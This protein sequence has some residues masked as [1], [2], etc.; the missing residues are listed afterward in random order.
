MRKIIVDHIE[1]LS[2]NQLPKIAKRTSRSIEEVQ[3]ALE[4]ISHL[5]PI[6]GRLFRTDP[7]PY[8]NPD[9]VLELIDGEYEIQLQ[10]DYYPKLGISEAYLKMYMDKSLDPKLRMHFRKKIESAKWLIESIEQRRSTLSRVVDVLVKHQRDFLDRGTKHLKP[11]KMQEV[12]DKLGLHVSTIS[13]TISDKYVQ[14]PRGIFSLKSFFTGATKSSDGEVESRVGVKQKVKD[15]I[16][17]EN[18]TKPLSDQEIMKILEMEGLSIARRTVTKYRKAL[19]VPS[20][21]QRRVY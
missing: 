12:A 17:N 8:V 7:I 10:N 5:D 21:R 14:A 9:V 16:D 6:P 4:N 11:L 13:R 3:D 1:D 2:K 15:L 18:K 19:N 20:S